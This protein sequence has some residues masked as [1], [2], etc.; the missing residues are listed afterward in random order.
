MNIATVILTITEDSRGEECLS[1]V[2]SGLSK[3]WQKGIILLFNKERRGE[4][5]YMN[6]VYIIYK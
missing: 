4:F 2:K 5:L 3:W 6:K 1:F